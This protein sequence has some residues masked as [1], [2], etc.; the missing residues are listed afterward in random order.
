MIKLERI[1]IP[2]DFSECSR[3]ATNYAIELAKRFDAQIYLLHVVEP[4]PMIPAEFL[5]TAQTEAE[6]QL[7]VWLGDEPNHPAAAAQEIRRGRPF[8]QITRYAK[9]NDIDLIV[10]GTHGHGP[11]THV[12][13]G[14]VAEKVVRKA[15]C[16]VLTVGPEGHQFVLP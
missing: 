14:S 1:L 13:I 6:K 4:L 15:S 9:E 2:T 11:L 5:I 12:L 3:Q 7:R 8:V 10:I 16:P